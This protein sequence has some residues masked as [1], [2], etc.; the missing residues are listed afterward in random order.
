MKRLCLLAL[1]LLCLL[2]CLPASADSITVQQGSTAR[3]ILF[4]LV[5]STDHVTALTGATPTV[6]LSKNG[7]AFAAPA[8]TV[9]ELANGWYVLAPTSA[10]T[11]AVGSLIVHATA[12]SGDPADVVENVVAYNP[13]D[14]SLLGLTGVATATTQG[15]QGTTLAA[16]TAKTALI[17]TNAA[18]SPN[19]VTA[20]TGTA[21][22]GTGITALPGLVWSVGTR[23]VT[24]G[25]IG[26]YTGNTP[27]TGDAYLRLASAD[28]KSVV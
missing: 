10:D 3:K 11:G 6:T 19:A 22:N 1:S 17:A 26:T 24:G 7:A 4:L 23:T 8:G 15:T 12:T 18:D 2:P 14:A 9:T 5:Q 25:T 21:S 27:Q 20:Q 16:V 28:R 13:D